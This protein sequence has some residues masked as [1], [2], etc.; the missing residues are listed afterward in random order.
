MTDGSFDMEVAGKRV[1]SAAGNIAFV[2]HG[3]VHAFKNVGSRLCRS[4][5]TFTPSGDA[6]VMFCAFY[7]ANQANEL[8][9]ERR[10]EIAGRRDQT[11]AGPTL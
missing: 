11:I 10:S 5:Y 8:P 1:R 7:A 4:C 2:L 9:S 3:A 6:E